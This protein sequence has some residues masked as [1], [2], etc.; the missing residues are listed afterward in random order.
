MLVVL[1]SYTNCYVLYV[2]DYLLINTLFVD[3]IV[4]Y[5]LSVTHVIENYVKLMRTTVCVD[6]WVALRSINVCNRSTR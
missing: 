4:T 6:V 3:I 5:L 1:V 2:V